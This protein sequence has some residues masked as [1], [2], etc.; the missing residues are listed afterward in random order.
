MAIR[1]VKRRQHERRTQSG[2][3]TIVSAN[4]AAYESKEEGNKSSKYP[5]PVC[6]AEVVRVIMPN[7]GRVHF[8]AS[9]TGV[10]HPCFHLGEGLSKKRDDQT[11]DLF[12]C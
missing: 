6:G 1:L 11:L 12:K 8:E 4:W 5:C 3:I 9:L 7:G 10:K 2:R